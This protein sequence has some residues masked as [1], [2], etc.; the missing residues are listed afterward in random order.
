MPKKKPSKARAKAKRAWESAKKKHQAAL[1]K[2]RNARNRGY[3]EKKLNKLA[4]DIV[5]K[6]RIMSAKKKIY[7]NSYQD[8]PLRL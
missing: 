8:V 5:E 3:S 4:A 1:N 2:S 6:Q 7:D